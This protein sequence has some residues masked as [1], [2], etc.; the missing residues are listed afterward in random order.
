MDDDNPWTDHAASQQP[1]YTQAQPPQPPQPPPQ[2][3]PP[4][5]PQ[6]GTTHD[7]AIDIDIDPATTAIPDPRVHST[8]L[9]GK[10]QMLLLVF[11]HGFKGSSDTTFE[12][13]PSRLAHMLAETYPGLQV[14]PIV[15]PTY[16]TRGSLSAAV[17]AFVEWL[18]ERCVNL[19]S[20]P[21]IDPATGDFQR[22]TGRGGG[23]GSVKVIL[24]GHSMGGLIAVDAALAIARSTA[25]QTAANTEK[26]AALWPRVTGVIAY[27]TP[28]YGVHPGVFKNGFNKYAGY[29]QTAQTLGTFFAPMGVGLAANW[30]NKRNNSAPNASGTRSA[31][32]PAGAQPDPGTSRG[33][34]GAGWRNA[35]IATGAVALAGGAAASYFNKDKIGGAY[36][37]V[38]DHLAFVGNLF[39][40]QAM[41]RRLDDLVS[42][43]QILFHCYYT[44]LPPRR[45]AG[46]QTTTPERTF[47]ILPP[48]DGKSAALFTPMDNAK[49]ADEVDAHISMFNAKNNPLYFDLGLREWRVAG[50]ALLVLRNSR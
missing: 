26:P 48:R 32:A 25:S 3:Q 49:S 16:D 37:W 28:Y 31:S 18:T 1:A 12:D 50:P 8:G 46:T 47:I 9:E 35:L 15:Y 44:R 33:G 40:N 39:D 43:P 29:V 6:P 41:R 36:G 23:M 27:D 10:N 22:N 13:F 17:D 7:D 45:I 11:I 19:E 5:P 34:G 2:P 20:K 30:N 42:Q 38:S 14:E 24:A 21:V 4:S